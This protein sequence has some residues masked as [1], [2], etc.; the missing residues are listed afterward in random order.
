MTFSHKIA[1]T[2]SM[3]VIGVGIPHYLKYQQAHSSPAPLA[4]S[5]A[6]EGKISV[7]TI[8]GITTMAHLHDLI[9]QTKTTQP[10]I[11]K[12]MKIDCPASQQVLNAYASAAGN[13]QGQ[14]VFGEI[15]FKQFDN[16]DNLRDSLRLTQVPTFICYKDGKELFRFT[17][18]VSEEQLNRELYRLLDNNNY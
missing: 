8:I 2:L 12:I 7:Q 17:G 6:M 5:L 1:I 18:A 11:V 3:I 13:F 10:L 4:T 15:D 9:A 16:S 14:I